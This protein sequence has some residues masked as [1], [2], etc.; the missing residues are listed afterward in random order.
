MGSQQSPVNALKDREISKRL[1][2]IN[3]KARSPHDQK[4]YYFV[5]KCLPFGAAIS[6]S[7]FQRVSDAVA[8]IFVFV[9]GGQKIINYLDNYF[10]VALLKAMCDCQINTFL[11]LC[12]YINLPISMDKTYFGVTQIVFLGLLIDSVRQMVFIPQEKIDAAVAMIQDMLNLKSKKT[13]VKNLQKLCG[14]LNFFSRCIVPARAFTRRLY[15]KTTNDKLKSHH[16]IRVN[17]EMRLDLELWLSFL[18]SPSI[19]SRPFADFQVLTSEEVEMYS[20]SSRNM[21]LGCG[22]YCQKSWYV[23]AWDPKFIQEHNPSI[24]YLELYAVTVGIVNWIGRFS[25]KNITLFCDNI[26]VVYMINKKSASCRNCMVLIRFI[27]M[28]GMVHN[29]K[30]SAKYVDTKSNNISDALSRL[31]FD[32]FAE[33]TKNLNF[34]EQPTALPTELWPMEKL[35]L[36]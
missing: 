4:F 6:C 31:Q 9:S 27:V 7:H 11:D 36:N 23:T 12:K 18:N 32:R 35:W 29:V 20:D 30:I 2:T 25:G 8:H 3:S 24:A 1:K 28:Q 10:F 17:A 14:T 15:A 13:T 16:R 34:D 33:L 21:K 5:D 19:F 22:G 26:S